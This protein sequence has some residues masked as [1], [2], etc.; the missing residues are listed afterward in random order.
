MMCRW[1][2]MMA[3]WSG[4]WGLRLELIHTH[5]FYWVISEFLLLSIRTFLETCFPHTLCQLSF[6]LPSFQSPQ[7]RSEGSSKASKNEQSFS[8]SC[9]QTAISE[10]LRLCSFVTQ[11]L[12]QLISTPRQQLCLELFPVPF[13]FPEQRSQPG[14][15]CPLGDIWR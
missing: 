4:L 2:W 12:N 15:V 14:Q 1:T 3:M 7:W 13:L 6:G 8:H 5:G 9:F 10:P 11:S